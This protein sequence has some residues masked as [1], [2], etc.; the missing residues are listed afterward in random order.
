MSVV[1]APISIAQIHAFV[2]EQLS[3]SH[4]KYV[5]D[6]LDRNPDKFDEL[7]KFITINDQLHSAF[8]PILSEAIPD[9]ILDSVS[10]ESA[11]EYSLDG[12]E[13]LFFSAVKSMSTSVFG[14]EKAGGALETFENI[15]DKFR[16][17]FNLEVIT[18]HSVSAK[19]LDY[20]STIKHYLSRSARRIR[21]QPDSAPE[22]MKYYVYSISGHFHKF[23]SYARSLSAVSFT[24]IL[25]VGILIGVFLKGGMSAKHSESS[26][27]ESLAIKSHLIY[28]NEGRIAAATGKDKQ[29][30]HL[31]WLSNRIGQA[32]NP[33]KLNEFGF[34]LIGSMLLPAVSGYALISVFENDNL[35]KVTVYISEQEGESS[36]TQLSCYKPQRANSLCTWSEEL[37]RYVVVADLPVEK[38][39]PYAEV[40][41]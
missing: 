16:K 24:V 6:Y 17:F 29:T 19:L 34:E 30:G 26:Q 3:D 40:L 32:A 1:S 18:K 8:D 12:G 21:V 39:R 15:N 35:E 38:I 31:T 36:Q 20:Y 13:K 41:Q 2:D 27:I 9:V 7:Q 22:W 23:R 10:R 4:F 14:E 28:T 11:T 33:I 25:V 5:E 37:M